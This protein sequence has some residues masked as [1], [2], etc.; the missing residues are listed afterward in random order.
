MLQAQGNQ[1]AIRLDVASYFLWLPALVGIFAFLRDRQPGR[2]MLGGAFAALGVVAMFSA[3]TMNSAAMNLAA[4]PVTDALKDRLGALSTVAFSSLMPGLWGIA[5]ANLFWGV[6]LRSEGALAKLLGNL[7]F[8]QIAGFLIATGGFIAGND[9]AGN[10]GILINS[11]AI[12]A[13]YAIASK[14]LLGLSRE[15]D[16]L[17]QE[18]QEKPR[19]ASA[20]A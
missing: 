14:L 18:E 19:A 4:G 2:A 20:S 10:S 12:V 9:V 5:L 3:S 16:E 6:A 13:S 1:L 7:L 15:K 17:K 11:L 8:G